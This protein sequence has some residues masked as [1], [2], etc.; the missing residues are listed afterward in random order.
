MVAIDT[1]DIDY[2]TTEAQRLKMC[3]DSILDLEQPI[4][5]TIFLKLFAMSC[6]SHFRDHVAY[7][8]YSCRPGIPNAA[9]ELLHRRENNNSTPYSDISHS[10][11]DATLYIARQG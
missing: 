9:S 11:G 5:R 2:S 8:T 4:D 10:S 7:Q 6:L 1:C 3:D